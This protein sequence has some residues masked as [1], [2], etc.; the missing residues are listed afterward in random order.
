MTRDGVEEDSRPA[1]LAPLRSPVA[2]MRSQVTPMRWPTGLRGEEPAVRYDLSLSENPFPPL[3]SVIEALDDCID[4]ANRY[5]EFLPTRL[6]QVIADRLGVRADQV[7]VGSGATGVAMQ[8]MQTLPRAGAGFVYAA[9]TFDGY[10]IMANMVGLR[11]VA[12]PLDPH[13]RQDLWGMA[14]AVDERT[15]LIAVCRPHNPTG[16]VV[17][18]SELKAFLYAVPARVPVILD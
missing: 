17:P 18:A 9:P 11:P 3:P 7:V 10:P 1:P 5:P 16:T 6:P 4:M 13:G 14:R 12:V 2:P 15:G 8:I